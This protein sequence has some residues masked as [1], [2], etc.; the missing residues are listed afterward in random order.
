MRHKV[1]RPVLKDRTFPVLQAVAATPGSKQEFVVVSIPVPDFGSRA[2]SKLASEKGAQVARY[3]SVE[4]IRKLPESAGADAGKIEWLMATASDAGGVLP[5]W[6]QNMAMPGV[7]WK[8]VPL[9]LSW[10]AKD[11]VKKGTTGG[12]GETVVPEEAAVPAAADL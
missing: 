10:I 1:G 11:R 6:V 3:V 9:F 7:V 5:M 2:E 4:R 12:A 8:D